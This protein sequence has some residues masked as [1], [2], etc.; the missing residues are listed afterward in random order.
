MVVS[1][2][3]NLWS[4]EKSIALNLPER[5]NVNVLRMAGDRAQ[6][7][8]AHD[9]R[10]AVAALESGL[11]GKK[12]VCIIFD[13]LSRPTRT[14][15]VLPYVLEVFE[16]AGIRDE[17]VRFVCAL[18]THAPSD[19]VAFRKK[20]GGEVLERF[21]V[22]N[23]NPYEN[24]EHLGQTSLGTPIM[25]NKEFLACD[26]RIGIGSFVPHGF[27][28]YGGGYKIIM[29]GIAHI[30]SITHH[31]GTLMQRNLHVCQAGYHRENPLLEDLKEFGR[32]ARLDV[33]IDLLV[34][35][36]A[37]AVD[38]SVGTADEAYSRFADRALAHYGADVPWKADML[39]VNTFGK[40]NEATIGLSQA[41]ALLKDEGGYV[42]LLADVPEGQVVHYLL[43]KSGKET[44]GRLARGERIKEDNIRRIF[45]F[46][47]YKDI[48]GSF[49]YGK[50]EDVL[51]CRDLGE[52]IRMLDEEYKGRIP[53][54]HVIPD[55][56]IQV[57]NRRE[58]SC[59]VMG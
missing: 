16:K 19:N 29:P 8:A 33:K 7:L 40:G 14:Y 38:I 58:G 9:Y 22:Y 48:A 34:N 10:K 12:E 42:V 17:Q 15:Q 47:Q 28:G 23:H 31:H 55:G 5:W 36:E 20:L 45:V 26:A 11:K 24:C 50:K 51:W 13:D 41:S 52:I 49:W 59:V 54:V 30:D 57:A 4:G 2:K 56:T 18:G 37:E 1:L 53:D 21:P 43:G 3:H 44:G 39:F 25:V 35:S 6:V 46:S 32:K 27:C